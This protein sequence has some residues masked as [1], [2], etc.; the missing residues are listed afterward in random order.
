MYKWLELILALALA[1]HFTGM[2]MVL[3]DF[4]KEVIA[5][6]LELLLFML[7]GSCLNMT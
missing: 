1:F 2:Y 4:F 6:T 5:S 7:S 3:D